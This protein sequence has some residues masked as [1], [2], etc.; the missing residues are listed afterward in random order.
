MAQRRINISDILVGQPLPWDVFDSKGSLLLIKGYLIEKKSQIE[1]L[2]ERGLF[3]DAAS[4]SARNQNEKPVAKETPS[5]VRM[6]DHAHKRLERLLFGLNNEADFPGKLLEVAPIVIRAAELNPDVALAC[7]L[8][9]Q[10]AKNYPVRHC[11]DTAIVSVLVARSVN[12]PSEEIVSMIAAALTMNIGM[13]SHH[14]H[15]QQKQGALTDE[16]TRIIQSHPEEGARLLEAAGVSD[17]KW[18]SYVLSHHENE[19]GSGY[20]NGKKGEEIPRNCKIISLADRYCARIS[21]REYRKSVLPN[22]ALREIFLERGKGVDPALAAHFIK[23]LGIYPP[24]TLVRL[25]SGEIGVVSKRVV[26]T[27][28]PIVHAL[29]GPRGAPLSF[30]IKRETDREMFA[31][32]ETLTEEQAKMRFS[33]HQVWGDEASL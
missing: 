15:L 7:V 29:I 13:L 33:M 17:P 18:L 16:E 6:L 28:T 19:D 14:H 11:I 22:L 26:G 4:V 10:H 12:V 31:I 5:A 23:V 30:P 8:L 9:N 24:G 3:I 20:S 21:N 2:I 27:A 25:N 1:A 32:R